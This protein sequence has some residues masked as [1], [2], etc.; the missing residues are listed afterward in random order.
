MRTETSMKG[1]GLTT[2]RMD[3][4][5]TLIQMEPSMW[6]S[7]ERTN[8]KEKGLKADQM[9]PSIKALMSLG[10]NMERG[11]SVGLMV[12]VMRENSETII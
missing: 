1:S 9:A 2:K 10:R 8:S 5:R 6:G 3:R 4:E 12:H 7:G 11:S